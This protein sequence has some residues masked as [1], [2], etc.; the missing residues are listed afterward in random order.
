[1][2]SMYCVCMYVP[3]LDVI[4]I[5]VTVLKCAVHEHS[6]VPT[7]AS[8]IYTLPVLLPPRMY[9]PSGSLASVVMI[10]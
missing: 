5:L 8:H 9:C 7:A 3:P 2:C 1:V 6:K 4:L 10:S